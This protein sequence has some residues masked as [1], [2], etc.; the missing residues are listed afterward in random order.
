V[1]LAASSLAAA[2]G[3]YADGESDNLLA[4]ER[5]I[6]PLH[7]VTVMAGEPANAAE[8]DSAIWSGFS[9]GAVGTIYGPPWTPATIGNR[10]FVLQWPGS[11]AGQNLAQA[12]TDPS[13]I[14]AINT[15]A[16]Y[17]RE[18]GL[19]KGQLIIRPMHEFEEN[20]YPWS[21]KSSPANTPAN[22]VAEYRRIAAAWQAAAGD[23]IDGFEWCGSVQVDGSQRLAAYPGDD[24]VKYVGPD[25]YLAGS[26]ISSWIGDVRW[27]GDFA[28][29]HHKGLAISE[30]GAQSGGNA[31]MGDDVASFDTLMN[32]LATYPLHHINYFNSTQG[33]DHLLNDFPN[34]KADLK[35]R[36]GAT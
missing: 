6:A 25:L 5:S 27:W 33:G 9:K 28:V 18:A 31:G 36:L 21:L 35:R 16:G 26:P 13:Q 30:F 2:F 4:F 11:W 10:V 20:W 23:M 29:A 32:T 22:Y 19:G 1:P 15:A 24:I 12:L 17:L 34:I 14:T 3:G 8:A 7:F